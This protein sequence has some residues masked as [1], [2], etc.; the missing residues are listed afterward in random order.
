M[1]T[2][3]IVVKNASGLQRA[4]TPIGGRLV[5]YTHNLCPYAQRVALGLLYKVHGTATHEA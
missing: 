2:H 1:P 3:G 4:P 5:F